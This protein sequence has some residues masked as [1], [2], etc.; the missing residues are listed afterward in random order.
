[1]SAASRLHPSSRC[2][3][4]GRWRD[5]ESPVAQA[6]GCHYKHVQVY[7]HACIHEHMCTLVYLLHGTVISSSFRGAR[8]RAGCCAAAERVYDPWWPVQGLGG[9]T[10]LGSYCSFI[11]LGKS[12]PRN[13][14]SPSL[15]GNRIGTVATG[16]RQ[17]LPDN[18][19][20]L[21]LSHLSPPQL[22][23]S[24]ALGPNYWSPLRLSL[25]H[26]SI[27]SPPS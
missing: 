25:N 11:R 22:L 10:Y 1:M 4:P 16:Q 13:H 20:P 6:A 23:P 14:I 8:E 5:A 26:A 21:F 12:T 18:G 24:A 3:Q 15:E 17:T 2:A 9:G 27:W 7:T 19:A